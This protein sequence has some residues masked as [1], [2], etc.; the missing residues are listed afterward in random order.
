MKNFKRLL[1]LALVLCMMLSVAPISTFA[2]ASDDFIRVFHMDVGRKYFTV[3]E[4]K[5]VIDTLSA[6]YYT[7][8]ELAIGNDGLRFLLDDMSVTVGETTYGS[9]DVAAGVK[10][11]NVNYSHSGEWSQTEMD[12][13][14]AY[15]AEKNIEIIPLVNNPGHMDAIIDAMEYVGISNPAY[16][17]SA[18]TVDV[19]NATAVAF[20]QALVAKYAAYF[21]GKG[22]TYFNMGADEY[23]NDKYTS[24]SMGFGNLQSSGY[25]DEFITYI[26]NQAAAIK[27]LG[28]IPVAFNDGIYFNNV[29]YGIMYF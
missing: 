12:E 11:G 28:M 13:I 18:R 5:E 7:H 9:A 29:T 23:A 16:N 21:A 10:A 4:V 25:Y 27:D 14:M 26:N 20:T 6:N 8:L 1:A 17:Y 24:G 2:A 22:C 19:N 3:D 15:A